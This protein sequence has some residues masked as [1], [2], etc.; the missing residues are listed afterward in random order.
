MKLSEAIR[1]GA[2]LRP[3]AKGQYFVAGA[4]CAIGAALEGAGL[5][6]EGAPV[7]K[8]FHLWPREMQDDTIEAMYGEWPFLVQAAQGRPV[9]IYCVWGDTHRS[10]VTM[11]DYQELSREQIADV[12]E[13]EGL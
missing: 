9:D 2:V 6:P 12:V 10:V 13:R 5:I 11:N 8:D 3:K 1:K 7:E 4:S